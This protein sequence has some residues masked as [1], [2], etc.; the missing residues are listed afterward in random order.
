MAERCIELLDESWTALLELLESLEAADW[1][2]PTDCP[3]WTVRDVVSH[4]LG[5][6]RWLLGEPVPDVDATGD[7][8]RNALGEFNE[9]WVAVRRGRS[10]E[11][12]VTE[13]RDVTHRRLEMLRGMSED[14]LAAPTISPIGEVPYR[15]F[16]LVRVWDCVSHE[17]DVRR[18]TGRPGGLDSDRA[19]HAVRFLARLLPR[20]VGKGGRAPDGTHAR[21]EIEGPAGGTWDV[22]VEA[23]RGRV[24]E[25]GGAATLT[26]ASSVETFLRLG[27]G[28]EAAA[29][30]IMAGDLRIDGDAALGERIAAALNVTP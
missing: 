28:R 17:Q 7:H 12:T 30:S 9:R 1:D 21:F 22:V 29:N 23:G 11:E 13:F 3:G 6:E 10:G 5:T 26:L 20:I 24:A 16:M 18:A 25:D 27:W 8:V 15:D 19:R 4:V 2:R 14:E